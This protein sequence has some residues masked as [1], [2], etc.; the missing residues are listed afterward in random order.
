MVKWKEPRK[1]KKLRK[2]IKYYIQ[3]VDQAV[4]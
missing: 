3:Q 2:H 1:V 4:L